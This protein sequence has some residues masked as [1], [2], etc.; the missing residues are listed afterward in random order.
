M[1]IA[2]PPTSVA[3]LVSR[4]NASAAN[5]DKHNA[6]VADTVAQVTAQPTTQPKEGVTK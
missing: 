2:N 1:S 6:T 5:I 4:V 3:E